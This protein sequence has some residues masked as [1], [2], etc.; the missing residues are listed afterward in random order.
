MSS[1]DAPWLAAR[2]AYDRAALD[3]S[4]VWAIRSWASTQSAERPLVVVDLGSGTGAALRRAAEWLA[5]HALD[6]YAVDVDAVLLAAGPAA[7]AREVGAAVTLARPSAGDSSSTGV[8]SADAVPIGRYDV[9]IDGRHVRVKAVIGDALAPLVSRGGPADGR[10][11]LVLGHALADLLPL[12][13]L[14]GRITAL[15]RPG[16]L[17][18]LALTYDGQTRFAPTNDPVLDERIVTAYHRHMDRHRLQEPSYGGS[19]A[20]TRLEAALG[21]AGLHLVHAADAVWQVRAADGPAGRTVLERLLRFVVES[22]RELGDLPEWEVRHWEQERC[23]GLAAEAL[24]AT[25]GHRDLLVRRP[26]NRV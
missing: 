26:G 21:S 25:V 16:G 13:R 7:W 3:T 10:V 8:A 22:V 4:I 20:G 18:H 24:S 1:F 15:L 6:A 2:T 12:D 9:R 11:D 5:P 23:A 19:T 17:A 14:L